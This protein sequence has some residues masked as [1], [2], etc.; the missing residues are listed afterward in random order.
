MFCGKQ[1]LLDCVV[2][3]LPLLTHADW[4]L[5]FDFDGTLSS[6]E[7]SPPV[8]H[9]FFQTIRTLRES[10]HIF[11]GINTGRSLMQTLEGIHEAAFPFL[12]DYIIAREREI[13][14]PNEFGRWLPVKEWN[15]RCDKAHK[16]LFRKHRRL[17]KRIRN[18]I[19]KETSTVWG[20]QEGE[21]AGMVAS[22]VEEMDMITLRLKQETAAAENLSYQRNGIYL[23]FS[24]QDYHKG[25]A[26]VEVSRRVGL[27]PERTFAIG[28]SFNDLDMLDCDIATHL[29]CPANACKEVKE[30]IGQYGGYIANSDAG[31]GVIEA[32]GVT[33]STGKEVLRATDSLS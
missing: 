5:A 21:P 18:W 33:F 12:P 2:K 15:S 27:T 3:T 1:A 17:L 7:M 8:P 25:S 16:K 23:R 20:E 24:H 11:W 22:S 32:L 4:L 9:D 19:E 28:D 29:A 30:Q 26:L 10:H 14:T 31:L 6:P 13:Y